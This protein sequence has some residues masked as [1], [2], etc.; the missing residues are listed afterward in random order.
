MKK[1]TVLLLVLLISFVFAG[2]SAENSKMDYEVN[3]EYAVEDNVD[4]TADN[5]KVSDNR[6]IIETIDLSVQTK[7]FDKLIKD[8][9][10][11]IEAVGG[12]IESSSIYGREYDSTDTRTAEYKVRIPADKSGNFT[13]YV[14]KNSTVINK[15]LTTEDVTLK[16]V[17]ME[18]RVK[19]LE[20]EK[21]ALEGL[22]KKAAST[23]EIIEIREKLTQVIGDIESYKSQLRTYDNLVSYSTVTMRIS[24]VERTAVV[25]KQNTWQKIGTNLKNNF[26]NVWDIIVGIFVF[27]ISAIPYLIPLAI[28]SLVVIL[29]LKIRKRKN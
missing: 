12:Y 17:D 9:N 6:K 15:T 28:I 25:E 21:T 7:Q 18:S 22:L 5:K 19:V 20:A 2:C 29:I 4:I 14:S 26:S 1:I 11:Q 16:Y 23:S 10:S 8:L 3:E 13:D 24:E 27:I